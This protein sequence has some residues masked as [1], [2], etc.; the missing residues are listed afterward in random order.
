MTKG[1]VDLEERHIYIEEERVL[2]K[3]EEHKGTMEE[4]KHVLNVL[5]S[6]IQN[7]R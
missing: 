6:L 5:G 2:A 3:V 4:R 7:G 1:G